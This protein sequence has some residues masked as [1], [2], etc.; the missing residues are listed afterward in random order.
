MTDANITSVEKSES[1]ALT[2]LS[3]FCVKLYTFKKYSFEITGRPH[4]HAPGP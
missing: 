2:Q 4:K 1:S 3:M